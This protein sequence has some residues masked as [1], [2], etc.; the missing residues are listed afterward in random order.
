[1]ELA[2]NSCAFPT[3]PMP[4]GQNDFD[5]DVPAECWLAGT[6]QIWVG[7]A[8]TVSAASLGTGPD[9]RPLGARIGAI[10]LQRLP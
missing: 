5:W 7:I 4:P 8:P 2:V 1:M 3:R 6:N 9:T 10:R